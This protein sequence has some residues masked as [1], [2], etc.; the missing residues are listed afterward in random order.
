MNYNINSHIKSVEDVKAFFHHIVCE[1]K[2]NFHP[3]NNFTDYIN[4]GD[5]T[6]SLTEYEV[7][8]YYRLM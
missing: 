2:L 8:V 6:S 3:D 7:A 1:R 4:Y 5:K